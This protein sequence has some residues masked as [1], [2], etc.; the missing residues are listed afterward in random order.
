MSDSFD[1][2]T[3]D[4]GKRKPNIGEFVAWLAAN[5]DLHNLPHL[6][7]LKAAYDEW[8]VLHG[9]SNLSARQLTRRISKEPG[10]EAWRDGR[11]GN[12]TRYKVL[13]RAKF[14]MAA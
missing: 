4:Y 3:W 14:R 9:F 10:I 11:A 12:A 7:A 6:R 5:D 8:A 13:P 1:D 2:F